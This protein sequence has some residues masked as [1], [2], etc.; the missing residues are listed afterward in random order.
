M[1]VPI[2]EAADRSIREKKGNEEMENEVER[3]EFHGWKKRREENKSSL[4]RSS[5]N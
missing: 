5:K 1:C 4:K 2:K 3:R